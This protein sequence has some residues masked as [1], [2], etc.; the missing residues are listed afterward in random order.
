[1]FIK[2]K[3]IYAT[4]KV[5]S[6]RIKNKSIIELIKFFKLPEL[7][8]ESIHQTHRNKSKDICYNINC[9]KHKLHCRFF[10]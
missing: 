5:I 9:A 3:C 6:G 4:L 2:L 8:K 10:N 7:I 1:M